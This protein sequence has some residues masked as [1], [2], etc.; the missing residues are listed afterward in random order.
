MAALGRALEWAPFFAFII[1][2]LRG[3]PI[4][5]RAAVGQQSSPRKSA[6]NLF[7]GQRPPGGPPGR[8]KTD[9]VNRIGLL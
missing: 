6:M 3:E 2:G 9:P 8:K 7:L 5:P 1:L 4:C